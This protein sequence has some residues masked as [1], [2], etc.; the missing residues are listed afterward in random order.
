[1]VSPLPSRP[2]P[3]NC[4][5]T[6]NVNPT[7]N[8]VRC[9]AIAM[10]EHIPVKTDSDYFLI[11]EASALTLEAQAIRMSKNDSPAAQAQARNYHLDAVRLLIGQTSRYL[12]RD[13]PAIQF[14]PWGSATLARAGVGRI[15]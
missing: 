14:K 7:Q 2:T 10:L 11:Q 1:M 8:F 12:G 4:C 15:Y 3:W 9:T 5:S 13:N 6:P